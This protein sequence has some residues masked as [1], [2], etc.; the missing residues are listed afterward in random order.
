MQTNTKLPSF[1][2]PALVVKINLHRKLDHAM[3][4]HARLCC[5]CIL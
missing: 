5:V 1:E 4:V 2:E 3:P